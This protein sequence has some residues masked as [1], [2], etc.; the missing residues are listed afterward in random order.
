MSAGDSTSFSILTVCTGNLARSP[1]A[2]QL[3]AARLRDVPAASVS[4]AGTHAN[5]GDPMTGQAAA[6]SRQYGGEPEGHHAVLLT[7][8]AV[9][10]A[11]LV[12]T[13]TRA[14]RA[15]AV[16]LA[17]RASRYTFT[18]RQFAHLVDSVDVVDFRSTLAETG[19]NNTLAERLRAFVA[20]A[21]A[22]RGFIMPAA[23]PADDDIEDPYQ[24]SQS[25]Y[26]HVGAQIDSAVAVIAEAF[27]S[28]TEPLGRDARGA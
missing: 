20:A 22:H 9:Q 26:N 18:L 21:A 27:V 24:Q 17:P 16:T 11:D 5:A 12:L 23:K 6:L 14:H 7:S 10:N 1:L 13:A 3:L 8:E 2:A 28:L 15:A 19:L 4:S 25:V